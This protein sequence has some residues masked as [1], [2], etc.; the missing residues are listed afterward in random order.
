M[1]SVSE[2]LNGNKP[3]D[4]GFLM[5]NNDEARNLIKI[6]P[7]SERFVRPFLGSSEFIKGNLRYCIWITEDERD[8]ALSIPA[9]KDRVDRVAD[10]RTQS[11]K[12]LTRRGA[13][14][15]YE[16]QQ[17]RQRGNET[18]IVVPRPSEQL[19]SR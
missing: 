13:K 15:P 10:F 6:D 4:G 8:S 9:I 11:K 18:I 1:S 5:L 19:A 14:T 17:V 7:G 3:V 12:E 16:F 2:M